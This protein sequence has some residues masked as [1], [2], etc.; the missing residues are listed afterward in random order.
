MLALAALLLGACEREADALAPQIVVV[1]PAAGAV[2]GRDPVTVE[3]YAWDDRGVQKLIVNGT[4]LLAIPPY[5]KYRGRKLA[6]FKFRP[7]T[8][9]GGSVAYR[10]RAVD[11]SGRSTERELPLIV[12]TQ[13]PRFVPDQ[14]VAEGDAV[15][16]AGRA[17]DDQKVARV[18]VNGEPVNVSPGRTVS[19]YTE[20]KRVRTVS[21]VVEDAVGNRFYQNYAVAPPLPATP[22]G[23][24]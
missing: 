21:V 20:L 11:N 9:A 2:T 23:S 6:P 1:K 17:T 3:G 13:P 14:L 5:S 15:V 8:S 10:L 24:G 4:D 12:D 18:L 22:A 16:F 7:R 19:F